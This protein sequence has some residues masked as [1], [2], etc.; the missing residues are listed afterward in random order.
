MM[1]EFGFWVGKRWNDTMLKQTSFNLIDSRCGHTENIKCRLL[2]G[3][4]LDFWCDRGCF[5]NCHSHIVDGTTS[6]NFYLPSCHWLTNIASMYTCQCQ[7]GFWQK[8]NEFNFKSKAQAFFVSDC[9]FYASRISASLWIRRLQID[10]W[11][12]CDVFRNRN[13]PLVARLELTDFLKRFCTGV[14]LSS[15][16]EN[17]PYERPWNWCFE[18]FE[19]LLT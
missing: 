16:L 15:Y 12:A 17:R 10:L 4:A 1:F 8:K 7:P 11:N 13:L 5:F 18:K 3:T 2:I 14:V 19:K 6:K 9:N